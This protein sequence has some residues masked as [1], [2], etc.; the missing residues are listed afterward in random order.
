MTNKVSE[1]H[2]GGTNVSPA[3][4]S[5]GPAIYSPF[6]HC[7]VGEGLPL[8]TVLKAE[9]QFSQG[10][11]GKYTVSLPGCKAGKWRIH[12]DLREHWSLKVLIGWRSSPRESSRGQ[13]G[14]R[15]TDH[16]ESA[17]R[18]GKIKFYVSEGYMLAL[19]MLLHLYFIIFLEKLQ[20]TILT[21][22]LQISQPSQCQTLCVKSKVV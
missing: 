7:G 4:M 14:D 15:G 16:V 12:A 22:N 10:Q 6:L 18:R 11:L 21:G 1:P 2:T 9:F 3:L 17:A 8:H 19:R 20:A 13:A 5:V